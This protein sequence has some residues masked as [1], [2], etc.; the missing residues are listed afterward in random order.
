[1]PSSHRFAVTDLAKK[2]QWPQNPAEIPHADEVRDFPSWPL[3]ERYLA[4]LTNALPALQPQG[5][6]W[7][8][9]PG[10]QGPRGEESSEP[11]GRGRRST[12]LTCSGRPGLCMAVLCAEA[13]VC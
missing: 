9:A 8:S 2:G 7:V 5:G 3:F 12:S 10:S 6:T 4:F 11:P 1:M 13:A